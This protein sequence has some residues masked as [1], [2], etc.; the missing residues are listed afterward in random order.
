MVDSKA[1]IEAFLSA[2]A[3]R[4]PTPGGGSVAALA[5]AMG[6]AMGQMVLSYSIGKKN[7]AA[8]DAPQKEALAELE[9]AQQVFLQLMVEDQAAFEAVTAAK[10][11]PADAP[12]RQTTYEA[13]L[14]ACI[15]VPQALAA[16]SV[17][18]LEVC[19]R[20]VEMS[21]RYLLSDLATCADLAMA[22]VR[23]GVNNVRVNVRDV[24]DAGERSHIEASTGQLLQHAT[25]LIKRLS[26][27]IWQRE[28][29][30]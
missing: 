22:A 11:L 5:G 21:N 19:D 4:Q 30:G 25:T 9:R 28:A 20:V 18:V 29:A 16:T 3:A 8:F 26:P 13:A 6:A 23:T 14:L 17:A 24:A 12:D 1:T 7:L 10:K 2:A 27:R 15:R